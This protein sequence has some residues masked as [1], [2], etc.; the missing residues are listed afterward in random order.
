ME[1][2]RRREWIQH[3]WDF[4]E[5]FYNRL[6]NDEREYTYLTGAYV[7]FYQQLSF[8]LLVYAGVNLFFVA[9]SVRQSPG[10]ATL[11]DVL[12]AATPIPGGLE[13]SS[14]LLLVASI[15]LAYY[16]FADYLNEYKHLFLENGQYDS[17]ARRAQVKDG[18]VATSVW[19][20]VHHGDEPVAGATVELRKDDGTVLAVVS[21]D[22]DGHFQFIDKCK[23]HPHFDGTLLVRSG[24][25]SYEESFNMDDKVIPSKTIE[26]P[27]RREVVPRWR[28]SYVVT[29]ATML[30]VAYC[31]LKAECVV[32]VLYVLCLIPFV[33]FILLPVMPS[34]L[35][36]LKSSIVSASLLLSLT[37]AV[38]ALAL[39]LS[40][41]AQPY[42]WAD[43]VPAALLVILFA[44][45]RRIWSLA[46]SSS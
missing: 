10:L 13:L 18:G 29:M 28:K 11:H 44:L 46:A 35:S 2:Q 40:R 6:S 22:A 23:E 16:A 38:T 5:L 4:D 14:V 34:L 12:K 39:S 43:V 26:V 32:G 27:F 33:L 15:P 8:Y 1:Y 20:M 17:F 30:A 45:N 41:I 25:T 9:S 42:A 31:A 36:V 21:T 3:N 37:I 7:T 19:G 24:N